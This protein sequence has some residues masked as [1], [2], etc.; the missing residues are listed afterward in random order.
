MIIVT[1]LIKLETELGAEVSNM[2]ST[3]V[4]IVSLLVN[5]IVMS[6]TPRLGDSIKLVCDILTISQIHC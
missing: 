4:C 2:K 1:Q 5:V 3:M 6:L